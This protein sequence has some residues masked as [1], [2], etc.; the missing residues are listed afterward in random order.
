MKRDYNKSKI[1]NKFKQ[2]ILILINKVLSLN[3]KEGKFEELI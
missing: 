1:K 2:K 3:N